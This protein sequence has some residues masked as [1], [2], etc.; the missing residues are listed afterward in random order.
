MKNLIL[1]TA[2][3]APCLCQNGCSVEPSTGAEAQAL[4]GSGNY[5][6][7]RAFHDAIVQT[8]ADLSFS[9]LLYNDVPSATSESKVNTSYQEI[10]AIVGPTTLTGGTISVAKVARF[11]ARPHTAHVDS[12]ANLSSSALD[13]FFEGNHAGN[14]GTTTPPSSCGTIT[15]ITAGFVA[16]PMDPAMETWRQTFGFGDQGLFSYCRGVTVIWRDS[17][18][19]HA[20]KLNASNVPVSVSLTGVCLSTDTADVCLGKEAAITGHLAIASK[21]AKNASND[22]PQIDTVPPTDANILSGSYLPSADLKLVK[23]SALSDM[24]AIWNRARDGGTGQAVF[25]AKL[26]ARGATSL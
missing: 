23:N 17:G 19:L 6:G 8:A 1:A 12:I 18:G 7:N 4:D 15:G 10:A 14:A 25:T 24:D 5:F 16:E 21:V 13:A 20:Q 26:V 22:E 2:L 9:P 3:L 11:S